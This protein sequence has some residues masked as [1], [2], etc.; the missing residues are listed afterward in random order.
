MHEH[1]KYRHKDMYTRDG[2]GF[3]VQVSRH[4]VDITDHPACFDSEG[5]H[6]WCIYA[7]IYPKHWHFG[8]FSGTDVFQDAASMMPLHCGPSLL[9]WHLGG[10]GEVTSVQV[11]CDYNHLHD[12]EYTRLGNPVEAFGVFSDADDLF[13]WLSRK[14]PQ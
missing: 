10:E 6:R 8:A 3:I 11:G 13:N 1:E 7:Y 9:R 5:P 12:N 2:D 14:E 4:S